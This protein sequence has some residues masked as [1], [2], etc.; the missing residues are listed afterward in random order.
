MDTFYDKATKKIVIR[1]PLDGIH[2]FRKQNI[3]TQIDDIGQYDTF[4][5]EICKVTGVCRNLRTVEINAIHKVKA[6]R[7]TKT[8]AEFEIEEGINTYAVNK[9]K[10]S[11]IYCTKCKESLKIIGEWIDAETN[12]LAM[13]DTV[14]PC[15][16]TDRIMIN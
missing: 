2:S 8:K 4:K 15:G 3:V 7:C 1:I 14:C 13:I 6:E 11:E 16:I 12:L 9:G 10:P 5:C